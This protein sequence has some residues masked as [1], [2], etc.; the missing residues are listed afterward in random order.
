M[1]NDFGPRMTIV[2]AFI[3]ASIEAGQSKCKLQVE[4]LSIVPTRRRDIHVD[5]PPTSPPGLYKHLKKN[6]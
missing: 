3:R 4:V 2:T 6:K 1:M 5:I